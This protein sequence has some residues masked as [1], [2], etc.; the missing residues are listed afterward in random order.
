MAQRIRRYNREYYYPESDLLSPEKKREE[1]ERLRIVINDRLE[2][3]KGTKYEKSQTYLRNAGKF[4]PASDVMRDRDIDKLLYDAYKFVSAKTSTVKGIRSAERKAI[5]SLQDHGYDVD[6]KT[7]QQ[8]Q[9]YME[10]A[11]I[12]GLN[13]IYGS[14]R[15]ADMFATA[16]HKG[17]NPR[18]VLEDFGYWSKN[19]LELEN[20]PKARN[21]EKRNADEYR[22]RI[23]EAKKKKKRR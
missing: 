13:R 2:E 11:R 21:V 1:Y 5:K 17:M 16:Q 7:F 9:E 22:R 18:E 23:E 20:A 6:S 14:T 12:R 4:I 8:F 19:R 3:F 15:I 10:E